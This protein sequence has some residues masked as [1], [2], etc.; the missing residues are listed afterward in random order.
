MRL[1]GLDFETTGLD[2]NTS[3]ITEVGYAIVDTDNM[4]KPLVLRST[5]CTC[6][7]PMPKDISDLTG[8]T[9]ELLGEC[10]V[11]LK[12]SLVSM[13]SNIRKY[14]V[15]HMVAHNAPFDR[16]FLETNL[17]KHSIPFTEMSW[18]DTKKD[19]PWHKPMRSTSLIT[20]A[21]EHG[22]L[23]PFPHAAL[24]DVFT[25]LKILGEYDIKEVLAYRDEPLIF[26][27]ALVDYN[28]KDK[29]KAKGFSW[30]ECEGRFYEKTWVKA[31][32]QSK[33]DKELESY[34]FGTKFLD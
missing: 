24:F 23:N 2:P 33:L 10:G 21:A 7:G 17:K 5:L 6:V 32:K 22:F 27:R 19:I 18:I 34:D 20:V 11:D 1:L 25:M 9:D 4:K 16:A 12:S 8:I 3:E 15:A 13:Q 28:T 31:V 26:I 30:Q 29:A 14:K